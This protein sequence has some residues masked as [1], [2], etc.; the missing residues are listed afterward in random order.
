MATQKKNSQKPA[1][2]VN[3][4]QAVSSYLA[5]LYPDGIPQEHWPIVQVVRSLALAVDTLPEQP[6]LWKQYREALC[7][8]DEL[9]AYEEDKLGEII[10]RLQAPIDNGE[11]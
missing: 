8:L 10:T 2:P 3:N 6:A 9:H 5:G 1:E 11:D 7:D 4:S